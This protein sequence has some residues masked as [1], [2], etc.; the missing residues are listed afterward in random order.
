MNRRFTPTTS[1]ASCC[2]PATS[3]SITLLGQEPNNQIDYNNPADS[4]F[5]QAYNCSPTVPNFVG[6]SKILSVFDW[7][8][9]QAATRT[10]ALT[11]E[12]FDLTN[13]TDLAS[14]T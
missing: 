1:R 8:L 12:E 10:P 9:Q 7:V 11:V 4:A 13:E 14:S 5:N 3:T 2:R 6:W